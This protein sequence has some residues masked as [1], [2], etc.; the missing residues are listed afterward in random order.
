MIQL[1][2]NELR[3]VGPGGLVGENRNHG[4]DAGEGCERKKSRWGTAHWGTVK[5]VI[6]DSSEVDSVL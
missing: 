1:L 4:K 2:E 3:F 6:V 5:F